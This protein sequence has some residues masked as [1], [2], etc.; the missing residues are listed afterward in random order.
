MT[1]ELEKRLWS[2]E[3][4][5]QMGWHDCLIYKIRVTENV[6]L[7]LDYIL[8]WNEPE[9]EGFSFT[10]WVA[11]A[12]LVFR[13][14]KNF[15]CELDTSFHDAVEIQDIKRQM[16]ENGLLWTIATHQGDFQ[17][18]SEGYR[19]YIRQD[20]FFEFGQN[21]S[22]TERGGFSLE[23]TTNQHNPSRF[24]DDIIEQKRKDLEHYENAKKRHLKRQEKE[25]LIKARDNDEIDT[26]QYLL[27]KESLQKC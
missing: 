14:V 12:T 10:F 1:Y 26:K 25:Q 24:R 5:E 6:E 17:F 15:T 27:K 8:K 7:D 22:F 23:H 21:I 18:F 9:L 3:N 16:T 19:Q 13:Q 11:P 4:F 20:P 2:D